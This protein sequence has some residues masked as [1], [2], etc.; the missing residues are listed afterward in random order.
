MHN[1]FTMKMHPNVFLFCFFFPPHKNKSLPP[2][3]REQAKFCYRITSHRP[4]INL[5][6]WTYKA[7]HEQEHII[8]KFNYR[9]CRRH[10]S[11][12]AHSASITS[13]SPALP[14]PFVLVDLCLAIQRRWRPWRIIKWLAA[15][16]LHIM[17]NLKIISNSIRLT[18]V[19]YY[20]VLFPIKKKR[21]KKAPAG[22]WLM[23]RCLHACVHAGYGV[24]TGQMWFQP[25]EDLTHGGNCF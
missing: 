19:I 20:A 7:K 10:T 5:S 13:A 21:K 11:T 14:F 24:N 17:A 6:A 22:W 8:L 15:L 18:C 1:S 9:R 3:T 12:H 2:P 25:V 16:L 4:H 23:P